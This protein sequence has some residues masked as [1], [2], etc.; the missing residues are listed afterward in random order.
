MEVQVARP[1]TPYC[2]HMDLR[3]FLPWLVVVLAF[4]AVG[5]GIG[6]TF[7]L[8]NQDRH[9]WVYDRSGEPEYFD[10]SRPGCGHQKP[11]G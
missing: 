11:L 6:W 3:R 5:L 10:Y 2:S 7:S 1:L 4:G 8:E 9:R